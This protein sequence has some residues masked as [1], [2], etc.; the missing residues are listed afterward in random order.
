MAIE[1]IFSKTTFQQREGPR[2]TSGNQKMATEVS[3]NYVKTPSVRHN[4]DLAKNA[5]LKWGVET[6]AYTTWDKFKIKVPKELTHE[7]FAGNRSRY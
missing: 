7:Q 5:L 1:Q 4:F 6:I 3:R 2:R